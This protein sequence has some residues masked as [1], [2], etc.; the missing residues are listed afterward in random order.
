MWEW[1]KEEEKDFDGEQN[2]SKKKKNDREKKKKKCLFFY[3]IEKLCLFDRWGYG[4]ISVHA[5]IENN[6]MKEER[7][8]QDVRHM[9]E[10]DSSHE[11]EP[12]RPSLLIRGFFFL[13]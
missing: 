5:S 8:L 10:E 3:Q 9:Y 1:S 2:E 4:N 11:D 7:T 13:E 12:N 6:R